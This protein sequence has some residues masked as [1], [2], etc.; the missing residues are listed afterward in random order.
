MVSTFR[1]DFIHDY[2]NW[3][4]TKSE[5]RLHYQ[6]IDRFIGQFSTNSKGQLR[7]NCKQITIDSSMIKRLIIFYNF[8]LKLVLF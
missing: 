4:K 8:F 2:S 3:S 1:R 6:E 7:N 5:D